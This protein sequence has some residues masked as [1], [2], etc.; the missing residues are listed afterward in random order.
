MH[1]VYQIDDG[2]ELEAAAESCLVHAQLDDHVIVE[3]R[4]VEAEREHKQRRHEHVEVELEQT[5][6]HHEAS[7]AGV[8]NNGGLLVALHF[9]VTHYCRLY[10]Y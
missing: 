3:E 8:G 2:E 1:I 7:S 5:S 4:V 6:G 10:M 9:F